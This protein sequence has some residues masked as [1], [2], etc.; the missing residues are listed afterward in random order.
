MSA[1]PL[2]RPPRHLHVF[3]VSLLVIVAALVV[4]LFGVRMEDTA[5]GTGVVT[6][7]HVYEARTPRGGRISPVR[8]ESNSDPAAPVHRLQPGDEL[9]AGEPIVFLRPDDGRKESPVP[10]RAPSSAPRWVVLEVPVTPGQVLPAGALVAT[11][12]PLDPE[13]GQIAGLTV[14]LD[15]DEKHFGE[16]KP[17]QEVRLSSN[18]YNH[19]I[20]GTAR[21][22]IERLEPLGEPGPNGT[23]RFHAVVAVTESPFPLRLGSSVRAEVM[24]GR[25]PTY[26]IILEH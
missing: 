16:V 25:K 15:I 11:L 26:Q 21:G 18:M 17:G 20:H 9:S 19:R 23:R 8:P 1:K 12:A 2:P 3:G 14:R 24:V 7:K 5:P 6:A 10:L 13:T 4:L 22:R